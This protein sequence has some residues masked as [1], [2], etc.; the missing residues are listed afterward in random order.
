MQYLPIQQHL[1]HIYTL[2]F[3]SEDTLLT[4]FQLVSSG[5]SFLKQQHVSE[6]PKMRIKQHFRRST[7]CFSSVTLPPDKSHF[8]ICCLCQRTTTTTQKQEKC[9]HRDDK[10]VLVGFCFS[11]DPFCQLCTKQFVRHDKLRFKYSVVLYILYIDLF[12]LH[13]VECISFLTAVS[14]QAEA[15][16]QSDLTDLGKKRREIAFLHEKVL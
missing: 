14:H 16:Q 8:Y 2:Y 4:Y 1:M 7:D 10:G 15:I 11:C 5:F 3:Y 6:N 12:I 9:F 13:V